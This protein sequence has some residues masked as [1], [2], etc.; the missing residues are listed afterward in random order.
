MRYSL[1]VNSTRKWF[2][3]YFSVRA[4]SQKGEEILRDALRPPFS[5]PQ[6]VI[7][8]AAGLRRDLELDTCHL[9]V[10]EDHI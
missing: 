9:D 2:L 4:S 8:R 5:D 10:R 7:R 1:N 3:K 6:F